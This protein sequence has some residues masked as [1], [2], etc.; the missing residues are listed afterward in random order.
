MESLK[1]DHPKAVSLLAVVSVALLIRLAV[2]LHSYSG[3]LTL[4]SLH[5]AYY[6]SRLNR[7]PQAGNRDAPHF[8]DYEAQ[9]HWMELTI[10]LPVLDW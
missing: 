8:G 6:G 10:N 2:G 1:G 5:G 9:R 3:I 4:K 7:T